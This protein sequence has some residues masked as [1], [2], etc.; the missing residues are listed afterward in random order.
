M[1]GAPVRCTDYLVKVARYREQ[2]K[3]GRYGDLCRRP[4]SS[5][6]RLLAEMKMMMMVVH[7]RIRISKEKHPLSLWAALLSSMFLL[8]VITITLAYLKHNI[9]DAILGT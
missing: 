1:C 7:T 8:Q 3:L 9:N 2:R 6:G 5:T 4:M